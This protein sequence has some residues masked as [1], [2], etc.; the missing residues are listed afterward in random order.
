MTLYLE[1]KAAA[2]SLS[3]WGEG[4]GEGVL[5]LLIRIWYDKERSRI[6]AT[7]AFRDGSKG[8]GSWIASL[9]SR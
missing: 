9:R 7:G 1:R 6:G 3:P 5:E 8:R 2:C 4:W